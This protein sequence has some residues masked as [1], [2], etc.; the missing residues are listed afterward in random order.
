MPRRT[1]RTI[2]CMIPGCLLPHRAQALCARHWHQLDAGNPL[3]HT[4]DGICGHPHPVVHPPD[5]PLPEGLADACTMLLDAHKRHDPYGGA[6][7]HELLARL[8][9]SPAKVTLP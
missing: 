7:L 6:R 3:T 9:V 2:R 4:C 8:G 1:L 5:P